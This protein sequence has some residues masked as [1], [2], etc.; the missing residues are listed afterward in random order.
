MM[1]KFWQEEFVGDVGRI[2]A[3]KLGARFQGA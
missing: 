1:Y 2:F 3:A